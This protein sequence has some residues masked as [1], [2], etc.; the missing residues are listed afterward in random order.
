M[1]LA[2]LMITVRALPA[3]DSQASARALWQ[4][5]GEHRNGVCIERIQRAWRY[6]LNFYSVKPLPDCHLTPMPIRITQPGSAPP[7]ILLAPQRESPG[8]EA[9]PD[10]DGASPPASH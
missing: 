8:P 1:V 3:I 2:L 9:S 4:M 6:G 5:I 7:E 10:R